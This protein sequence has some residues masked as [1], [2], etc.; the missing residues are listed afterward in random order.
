LWKIYADYNIGTADTE[1]VKSYKQRRTV[2]KKAREIL[3][4]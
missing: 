4:V 1:E 2:I 3:H